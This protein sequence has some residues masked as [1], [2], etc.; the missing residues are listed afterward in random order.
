MV[1]LSASERVLRTFE[2]GPLDRLPVF[3]IIHNVDFVERVV[4]ERVTPANAETLMCRAVR[5]TLDLVRHFAIPD[6]L[7]PRIVTDEDGFQYRLEWWTKELKSRPIQ[8]MDDAVDLMKRDIDTIYRC[9]DEQKFCHQAKEHVQLFGEW[10][11]YPEEVNSHFER[12]ASQ[13]GDTMMIAP[14]TVPGLYTAMNRYGLEWF[15]YL[16]YDYPD[17]TMQYYDA[18]VNHELFRIDTFGPT[19]LSKVAMISEALAFNTSLMWRPDFIS[20]EV[21]PRLKKCID[22]WKRYGYYVIWHSDGNKWPLI[23]DILDLGADSVNPCEPLATMEV[24]RFRA[25]Y[26]HAVI[27]SMIDCQNLLA[28]GTPDEVRAATVK[29]I[30]DSGAARTLIGSTSEIHPDISVENALAMYDVARNYWL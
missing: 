13:L 20:R 16:L 6:N 12:V 22:R 28:F 29:A 11:D 3:D 7:E 2:G 30:E 23:Q 5:E 26:P 9:I 15:V 27:G 18:L 19:G 17:L 14:E 25:E 10:Y 1:K 4:Q 21:Y 8:S 24:A